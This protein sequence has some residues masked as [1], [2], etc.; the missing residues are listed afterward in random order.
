MEKQPQILAKAFLKQ[1]ASN[2]VYPK[3]MPLVD[4]NLKSKSKKNKMRL[5][6]F[7]NEIAK[8]SPFGKAVLEEAADAGYSLCFESQKDSCGFCDDTRKVIALN[9]ALSD[10][11]LIATLAHESRHAQQFVRGAEPDF[12]QFNVKCELMS[13]RAMEAD[14]ETAAAATCHEI[15]VNGGNPGPWNAFSEDS[16]EIGQGFMSAA[17][18]PNSKVTDAMLKSAFEGWYKDIPMMTSYEEGYIIDVME[19]AMK[20]KE[21]DSL[22]YDRSITSKEIVNM[23]CSNAEGKCYWADRPDVLNDKDKLSIDP[24]TYSCAERFFKVREMRTG[25]KPDTTYETLKVRFDSLDASGRHSKQEAFSIKGVNTGII[26]A[27]LAA[28]FAGRKGR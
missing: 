25:Q 1:H 5:T 23:F 2:K 15:R 28:Q 19:F 17:K 3:K 20:H 7:I 18:S 22:P 11:L 13:F 24:S 27:S 4:L 9:P 6:S 12:G 14:A 26:S 10:D 16:V 21:E 8:N